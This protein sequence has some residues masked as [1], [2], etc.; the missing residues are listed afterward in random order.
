MNETKNQEIVNKNLKI[1]KN[2]SKLPDEIIS[3]IKEYMPN[4]FLVF[5]NKNNYVSYHNFTRPYINNYENY[6]RDVIRRD[7]E[8]VFERIIN[9]N[10]EKWTKITKYLYKYMV[11]NNYLYFIIYYCIE[12]ESNNCRKIL[13]IF[14]KEHG[15][16]KNL[17]KK[18]VIKYIR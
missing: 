5:T 12:N 16:C 18:N 2:I 15:L 3:I 6:I 9:E 13:D 17:H 11:F 8:F 7:N 1:F 14:L 10:Y 4:F